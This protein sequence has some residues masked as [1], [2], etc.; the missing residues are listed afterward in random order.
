MQ[1]LSLLCSPPI[2]QLQT[3]IF[4][5][6]IDPF[7]FWMLMGSVLYGRTTYVMFFEKERSS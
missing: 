4:R 6:W 7:P 2:P 3:L 1:G 5:R